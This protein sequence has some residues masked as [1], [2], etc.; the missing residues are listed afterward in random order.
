MID[1]DD[2]TPTDR[3]LMR[4]DLD[5]VRKATHHTQQIVIAMHS[6]VTAIR[7]EPRTLAAVCVLSAIV[8]LGCAFAAGLQ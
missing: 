7:R 2:I 6:E 4:S 1:H 5:A 3:P 8:S